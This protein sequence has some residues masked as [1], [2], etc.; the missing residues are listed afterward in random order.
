[1]EWY[2]TVLLVIIG[3]LVIATVLVYL[4]RSRILNWIMAT[5]LGMYIAL[6]LDFLPD[7]I[8]IAGWGDDIGALIFMIG[9]IIRGIKMT[10]KKEEPKTITVEEVDEEDIELLE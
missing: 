2:Y 9:F 10:Q 8:P 1:M 5:I 7:F 4:F 6:P 3:L